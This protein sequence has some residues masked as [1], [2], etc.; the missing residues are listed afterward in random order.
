MNGHALH[1]QRILKAVDEEPELPGP[2]PKEFL[3]IMRSNDAVTVTKACRQIVKST[4][5]GIK[6]RIKAVM[7]EHDAYHQQEETQRL[8]GANVRH[9]EHADVY[10]AQIDADREIVWSRG[11]A[12]LRGKC[13]YCKAEK[14]LLSHNQHGLWNCFACFVKMEAP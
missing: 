5:Q 9:G 12:E 10:P 3:D 2:M 11:E 4:K 7:T 6:E 1:H 14:V 13:D 8:E